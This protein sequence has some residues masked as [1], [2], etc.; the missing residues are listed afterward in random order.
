MSLIS[1]NPI[2]FCEGLL[3]NLK[4]KD[5]NMKIFALKKIAVI[6]DH[7]WHLV[8][9]YIE[10]I[11]LLFADKNFDER[12]IAAFI[13][14]KVYYNLE[15]I[16]LSFEYSLHAG[17][18]FDIKEDSEY[19]QCLIN[20]SIDDY[21]RIQTNK[22]FGVK[23]YPKLEN[24]VEEIL[25]MCFNKGQY[26]QTIGICLEVHRLDFIEKII[27]ATYLDFD[28]L[29]YTFN[30]CQ[31]NVKHLKF[32][33]KIHVLLLTFYQKI[34]RET[35]DSDY[36]NIC[37]C[38]YLLGNLSEIA[39]IL[40][41]LLDQ[42]DPCLTYQTAFDLL[43]YEDEN[44]L[45]KLK[46]L[47]LQNKNL[48]KQNV[49]QKLTQQNVIKERLISILSG[50]FKEEIN[51][52]ILF[53]KC[54]A[55]LLILKRIKDTV[56]GQ[57]GSLN[58]AIA[59]ANALMHCGTTIDQFLRDNLKWFGRFKNF[60]KFLSIA[61]I[62]IIHKGHIKKA[63]EVLNSYLPPSGSSIA[64]GGGLY[65][66]GIIHSNFCPIDVH[67]YLYEQIQE[68]ES[69][70]IYRHGA[71]LGS[72]LVS[73]GTQNMFLFKELIKIME[74]G[75]AVPGS[76]AGYSLGLL[77]VGTL[78]KTAIQKIQTY[79]NINTHKKSEKVIRGCVLALALICYGAK[80][81]ANFLIEVMKNHS[82]FHLRYGACY[83][84]SLSY[85]ATSNNSAL[86]FLLDMAV[87]DVSNDVR[88]AATTSIG[89]IFLNESEHLPEILRLLIQNYNP[90]VR[91]GAASAISIA[92]AATGNHNA[93]KL[94][95]I[96]SND[97][98]GFVV[99][100]AYIA[101]GILFMQR[102]E[103]ES[104][105]IKLF[106]KKLDESVKNKTKSSKASKIGA[107]LSLG[108]LD[109]GGRN[110]KIS[111][112][113]I[114]RKKIF[115]GIIGMCLFWQFW[116]WYPMI[117]M[118]S[119]TLKPTFV[120]GMNKDLNFPKFNLLCNSKPSKFKYVVPTKKKVENEKKTLKT[121][122]LSIT[123]KTKT[124]KIKTTLDTVEEEMFK[125]IKIQKKDKIINQIK[126]NILQEKKKTEKEPN[127]CII[128]NP[129]RITT[130]QQKFVSILKTNQRYQ[131]L[132]DRS[133]TSYL[134]LRNINPLKKENF[135]NMKRVS[136]MGLYVKDSNAS[137]SIQHY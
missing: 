37:K 6:I 111:L 36:R 28:V 8:S 124:R 135:V 33:R 13:A 131:I 101:M 40:F 77:M 46:D 125:C 50:Q 60:D 89:F 57:N 94:L 70:E 52:K 78:N 114:N 100:A 45:Y 31:V 69:N 120:I 29:S 24:I 116:N 47:I 99:Q 113:T 136:V 81:E 79:I 122:E 75:L 11:E 115:K 83:I 86:R 129:C 61:F 106:R 59:A 112:I 127:F 64:N 56:Y 62:G 18:L 49:A 1:L 4:G 55:D 30:L 14:S 72:G 97:N 76:A 10:I 84:I 85:I 134:L 95:R 41:K 58:M 117:P 2:V 109:A 65:A 133:I 42:N 137:K 119:L 19:V 104:P 51:L 71:I 53:M 118:I 121:A 9:E 7:C 34:L 67:G 27:Q 21:I 90:Y 35:G 130:S 15:E 132:N 68:S 44:F 12:Q 73:I 92:C 88:R 20:Q 102:N 80:E 38:L 91:Y 103:V 43:K 108:I 23:I 16:R 25:E 66:L 39:N 3:Y 107:F 17:N 87:S 123:A 105:E 5:N 26:K 74:K 22:N 126:L 98:I 128:E 93:W 48:K 110:M 96:L 63:R 32:R 54:R 82:D